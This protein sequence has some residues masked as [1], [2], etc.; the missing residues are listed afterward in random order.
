[1][2]RGLYASAAGM[3]AE[4]VRQEVISNNL[5][6]A[7]TSGFKRQ[8]ATFYTLAPVGGTLPPAPVPLEP[9]VRVG[10]LATDLAPGSVAF[11]GNPLDVALEGP[12]Y[13]VV[14]TPAGPVNTRR[15]GFGR[16]AGG[17]LETLDGPPAVGLGGYIRAAGAPVSI[18]DDGTVTAGG[19]RIDRLQVVE[20][21][22]TG[23]AR[24]GGGVALPAGASPLP[25]DNPR[26]R[27]GYREGSNVN[28][29]REMAAMVAGF[30]FFEANQK[31]LQMQDRT[32]EQATGEVA[33]LG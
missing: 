4:S 27:S 17:G 32:L 28:T 6:N 15:G 29:V 30:R 14:R 12:G 2:I 8:L 20:V 7:S 31:A 33:R 21:P 13:L 18:G 11:T 1:M 16:G 9:G 26:V 22:A 23:L 24:A 3:S 10:D 5:A 19:K 25:V